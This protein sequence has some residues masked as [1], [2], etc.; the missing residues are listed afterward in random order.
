MHCPQGHAQA[1]IKRLV[2]SGACMDAAANKW[3]ERHHDLANVHKGFHVLRRAACQAGRDAELVEHV[4]QY[5]TT[6]SFLRKIDIDNVVFSFDT[7]KDDVEHL[8]KHALHELRTLRDNG[9]LGPWIEPLK[10]G[11]EQLQDLLR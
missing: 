1:S 6:K 11:L 8:N 4:E 5:L 7:N 9:L 2:Q 10:P 3:L